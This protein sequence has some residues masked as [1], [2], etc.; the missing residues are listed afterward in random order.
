ML[1]L[2]IYQD[3]FIISIF[4]FGMTAHF[5]LLYGLNILQYKLE[6]PKIQFGNEWVK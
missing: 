3:E 6:T 1:S 5:S 2:F 4:P